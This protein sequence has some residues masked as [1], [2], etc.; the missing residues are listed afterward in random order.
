MQEDDKTLKQPEE[1]DMKKRRITLADGRYLIF[2]TFGEDGE[3]PVAGEHSEPRP[4]PQPQPEA[5]EER[6]V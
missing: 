4:E 1:D 6:H 2:Y 5:G 3:P